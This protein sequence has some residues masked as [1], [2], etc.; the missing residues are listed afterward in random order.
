MCPTLPP[1]LPALWLLLPPLLPLRHHSQLHTVLPCAPGTPAPTPHVLRVPSTLC[2]WD[3][4]ISELSHAQSAHLPGGAPQSPSCSGPSPAVILGP[5]LVSHVLASPRNGLHLLPLPWPSGPQPASPLLPYT[6]RLSLS[7]PYSVHMEPAALSLPYP[8]A[9]GPRP[10]E[11]GTPALCPSRASLLGDLCSPAFTLSDTEQ[12][13]CPRSLALAAAW[14][15]P[16]SA[17]AWGSL[18]Q[19][20]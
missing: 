14:C 2:P 11:D 20:C 12:A 3:A 7:G 5:S 9:E 15:R 13:R 1:A 8:A 10:W 17:Q 6:C 16:V 19:D 4:G 18:V